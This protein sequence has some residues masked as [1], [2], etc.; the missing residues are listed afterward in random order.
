MIKPRRG[1]EIYSLSFLDIVSC[2]FG[3]V[4]MLILVSNTMLSS[5]GEVSENIG[6]LLKS[7]FNMQ[8]ELNTKQARLKSINENYRSAIERSAQLSNTQTILQQNLSRNEKH[9][10]KFADDM[11]GLELIQSSLKR[12]TIRV[13][14]STKRDNM[15]GGIP[16]DSEYIIFIIDTSGS[17]KQIWARVLSVLDN[18]LDI[19]PKVKGIQVLS[20]NGA[21]LISGYSKK[22]IA[23]TGTNRKNILKLLSIWNAASNSSPVEGLS[24]ALRTYARSGKNISVY[25]FGDDYTGSSYDPVLNTL[26]RLNRN[27]GNDKPLVKVHAVGF[28]TRLSTGRFG[29]LM[30]E[31]TRR[32]N[33]TFLALPEK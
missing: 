26:D 27:S 24:E 7:I 32:N 19:H 8:T 33:G 18:V 10:K 31:V 23:D 25:I 29:I 16:V 5:P 12:S 14:T 30:R 21:Y 13:D 28:T 17:M 6:K 2:G 22:W 9:A 11:K 1:L 20:D 15:S 3:A 4:L